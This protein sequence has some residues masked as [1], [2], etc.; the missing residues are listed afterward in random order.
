MARDPKAVATFNAAMA[1]VARLLTPSVTAYDFGPH[2][3]VIDVGGG[4]GELLVAML[5]AHPI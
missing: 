3:K 4:T 5:Q 1:D 2:K